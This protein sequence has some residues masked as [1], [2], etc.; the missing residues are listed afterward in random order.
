MER[1]EGKNERILYRYFMTMI[2]TAFLL[3]AFG[4]TDVYANVSISLNSETVS[5]GST[6]T[7]KVRGTKSKVTWSSKN[8]KIATVSKKGKVKG[9]SSGKT[10]I[11]AKVN[12]VKLKCK[13]TVKAKINK[14]RALV[15]AGENVYLKIKGANDAVK[16]TSLDEEVATVNSAGKVTTKKEGAVTVKAV[17]KN[18]TYKCR[19][20]VWDSSEKENIRDIKEVFAITNEKRA[21]KGLKKLKLNY[22]LCKAATLRA[23]ELSTDF[24]HVRPDG[25]GCFS[26]YQEFGFEKNSF[27][28]ENIAY[29]YVNADKVMTGWLNSKDHKDNI[30]G[31]DYQEVGIGMYNKDG[32]RYWVQLFYGI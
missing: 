4:K 9:V 17:F 18:K 22:T 19:I 3:M 23:G 7:L 10:T 30:L 12:G 27:K 25:S 15:S 29:G 14:T 11:V 1:K 13:V 6:F 2:V 16:W 5:A 21:N 32:M 24:S 28:G 20:T 31:N 8:K 26:V